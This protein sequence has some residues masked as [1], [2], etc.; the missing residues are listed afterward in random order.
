[1][2]VCVCFFVAVLPVEINRLSEHGTACRSKMQKHR[3]GLGGPRHPLPSASWMSRLGTDRW[4]TSAGEHTLLLSNSYYLRLC[5]KSHT[6]RLHPLPE[7]CITDRLRPH[8]HTPIHYGQNHSTSPDK[9][10][11]KEGDPMKN[12]ALRERDFLSLFFFPFRCCSSEFLSVTFLGEK[13]GCREWMCLQE[14]RELIKFQRGVF[15]WLHYGAGL[16]ST[17]LKQKG[18]EAKT[19]LLLPDWLLN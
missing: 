12:D 9:P 19:N 11:M 1:M 6:D 5:Q 3:S 10:A 2:C 8:T 14:S 15:Q 4:R 18:S 16:L 7:W 17:V 13:R